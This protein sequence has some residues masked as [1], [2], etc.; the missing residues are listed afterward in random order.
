MNELSELV[1]NKRIKATLLSPVHIGSYQQTLEKTEYITEG[2]RVYL[3]N[4]DLVFAQTEDGMV[5]IPAK[6]GQKFAPVVEDADMV[7]WLNGQR[8]SLS[9]IYQTRRQQRRSMP[10]LDD[11]SLYSVRSH[12]GLDGEGQ[13]RPFERNG[14]GQPFIA[15]SSL[16]GALRN[17]W[18]YHFLDNHPAELRRIGS[19][20]NQLFN[21]F[22]SGQ[23]NFGSLRRELD[24]LVPESYFRAG[25][26]EGQQDQSRQRQN[27]QGDVF[28]MFQVSDSKPLD[29]SALAAEDVR[30][31]CDRLNYLY[32]R[33][34]NLVFY[35]K[36]RL[37]QECLQEGTS[38]EF[39]LNFNRKLR[40]YYAGNADEVPASLTDWLDKADA[41]FRIVWQYEQKFFS[42]GEADPQA[43]LGRDDVVAPRV[44]E[45]YRNKLPQPGQG[46][47]LRVGAGSG[48]HSVTPALRLRP[49]NDEDQY[50]ETGDGNTLEFGLG[51]YAFWRKEEKA[52]IFP[53]SRKIIRRNDYLMP[54]GWLLLQE[55]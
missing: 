53:K 21:D 4:P 10:A 29:N 34:G 41:F 44:L 7:G 1:E 40:E 31:L 51:F 52:E 49:E 5:E 9:R 2:N 19:S 15:G 30:V 3:A 48:I 27:I 37:V 13:Y 26:V 39:N 23:I 6:P 25:F 47:L 46:W 20:L 8:T 11:L 43:R 32:D 14:R 24:R 18:L 33:T 36:T 16:K 45:F 50:L 42:Q 12:V 54:L 55:V 28:R 17:S 35:E 38:F 22:D